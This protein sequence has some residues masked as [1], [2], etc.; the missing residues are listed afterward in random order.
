MIAIAEGCIP[1]DFYR[2]ADTELSKGDGGKLGGIGQALASYITKNSKLESRSMALSYLQRAGSPSGY[3]SL[4]SMQFGA[5]GAE[6]Y[7]AGK[8]GHMVALQSNRLTS[9]RVEKAIEK[10]K[11]VDPKSQI[12]ELAKNGGVF[13]G[14]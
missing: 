11:L 3:D 12:I 4:L 5:Y 1:T 6:L 8:F 10:L 9:I 14:S 7:K 2:V 13:F